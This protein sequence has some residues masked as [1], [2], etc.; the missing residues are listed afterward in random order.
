MYIIVLEP[1]YSSVGQARF[2][3]CLSAHK[4]PHEFI[5]SM[6]LAQAHPSILVNNL[7]MT[8]LQVSAKCIEPIHLNYIITIA[9]PAYNNIASSYILGYRHIITSNITYQFLQTTF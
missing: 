4:P 6:G 1:T 8:K 5:V 2:H 3:C 7:I 9:I